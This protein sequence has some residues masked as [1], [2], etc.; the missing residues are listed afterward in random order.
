MNEDMGLRYRRTRKIVVQANSQRC[1]VERQQY[2]L[3][4]LNQLEAGKRIIVVD[5]TWLNESNFIRKSWSSPKMPGTVV[6]KAITPSLS[7]IA[8]LDTDG[9]VYFSL[10]HSTTNPFMLFIKHLVTQLDLETPGW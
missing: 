4:M 7:M 9:R 6:R 8:A 1:L 2:A 5:E 10:S 3:I